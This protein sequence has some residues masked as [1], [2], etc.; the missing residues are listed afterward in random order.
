MAHQNIPVFVLPRIPESSF[1]VVDVAAPTL[2]FHHVGSA[3]GGT[4][5][6]T[7]SATPESRG[8][9]PGDIYD[10]LRD[11]A[12][13]FDAVLVHLARGGVENKT[14]TGPRLEVPA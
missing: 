2:D 9:R 8:G 5:L 7:P 13:Q 4:Q 14:S 11:A 12:P 3:T 6:F 10:W 1:S